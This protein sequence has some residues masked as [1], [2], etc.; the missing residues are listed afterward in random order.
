VQDHGLFILILSALRLRLAAWATAAHVGSRSRG[1]TGTHHAKYAVT[2]R[3]LAVFSG[4][5]WH[6]LVGVS[7]GSQ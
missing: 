1:G 5:V 6:W 4:R 7:H 2:A 3:E